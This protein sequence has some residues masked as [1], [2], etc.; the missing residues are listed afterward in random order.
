MAAI[1]AGLPPRRPHISGVTSTADVR[2][3]IVVS[4]PKGRPEV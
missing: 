4:D 1:L 2:I 3:K